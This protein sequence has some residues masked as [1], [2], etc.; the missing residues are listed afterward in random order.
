ML[1]RAVFA[2]DGKPLGD[3]MHPQ[4]WAG[5]FATLPTTARLWQ[6]GGFVTIP[7]RPILYVHFSGPLCH[8]ATL[9]TSPR[10]EAAFPPAEG[11]VLNLKQDRSQKGR[12]SCPTREAGPK[13]YRA[14]NDPAMLRRS[15][16]MLQRF[17]GGIRSFRALTSL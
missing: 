1:R 7:S 11:K 12:P 17:C 8:I 4:G 13:T 5:H 9:P 3:G 16:G 15:V 2:W 14:G 10:Q 6:S